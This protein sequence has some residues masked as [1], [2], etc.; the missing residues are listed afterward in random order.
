M[1]KVGV[2][3]PKIEGTMTGGLVQEYEHAVLPSITP[4]VTFALT[5]L[6]MVPALIKLWNLCA[7]G[8]YRALSFIR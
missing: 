5:F 4:S 3:V 2:N 8:I 1:L 6:T 7:D